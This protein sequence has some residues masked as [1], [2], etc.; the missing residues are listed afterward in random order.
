MRPRIGSRREGRRA[1]AKGS[2]L[3][4]S[5]P[6]PRNPPVELAAPGTPLRSDDESLAPQDRGTPGPFCARGVGG[7]EWPSRRA[8]EDQHSAAPTRAARRDPGAAHGADGARGEMDAP[9]PASL[10]AQHSIPRPRCCQSPLLGVWTGKGLFWVSPKP[11]WASP[12]KSQP[13]EAGRGAGTPGIRTCRANKTPGK[14]PP[15]CLRRLSRSP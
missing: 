3:I 5:P 7:R 9:K 6:A 10:P 12:S 1:G 8:A 14:P 13:P 11:Q 2:G 15:C 4:T